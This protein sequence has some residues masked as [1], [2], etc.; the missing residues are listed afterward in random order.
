MQDDVLGNVNLLTEILLRLPVKDALRCKCVCKKWMS[1]ISNPQFCYWHTLGLCRKHKHNNNP[2]PNPYLYPSGMLFQRTLDCLRDKKACVI[3]FN[4]C[5]SRFMQLNAHVKFEG[6]L[7]YL[8]L[9]SCN[10][11][12]LWDSI[13]MPWSN[14]LVKRC[15]FYIN[16]PST[17]C[18]VRID[19]FGYEYRF[20][21]PYLAFEPWKSPHYK[22]IFLECTKTTPK[23]SVYSSH[24]G[25]WSKLDVHLS[26]PNKN[27]DPCHDDGG[28]YCN[29]AIHWYDHSAYL[30]IDRL[31]FK[32][33]P[34]LPIPRT[35]LL[36]VKHFGESGGNLYLII[37]ESRYSG[38]YDFWEL[39]EDY[40]EWILKYH[41]DRTYADPLCVI[42][43]PPNEDEQEESI[44]AILLIGYKKLV[45]Y[46]LKDHSCKIFY[47]EEDSSFVD[48]KVYPYF[49][50]LA[51]I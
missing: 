37:E 34:V 40:S 20:S 14:K 17:G 51:S 8:L 46:N 11:L 6:T 41:V 13:P 36:Q 5:S 15:S 4:N 44:C 10:G 16:N 29:G 18:C 9:R 12:T 7:H 43:Q 31:C 50:T 28:V 25:S 47:E 33:L 35:G 32:N 26:F 42:C 39:K 19:K 23:M 45:S 48:V 1:L 2:N 30:D 27:F 22:V 49:E 24:T 3:P 21:R 38:R